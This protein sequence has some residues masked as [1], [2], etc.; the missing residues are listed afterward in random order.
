MYIP[1]AIRQDI[2]IPSLQPVRAANL[3]QHLLSRLQTEVIRIIQ[4]QLA[5]ALGEL[6]IRETFQRR[7]GRNGHEDGK[8]NGAMGKMEGAGAGFRCLLEAIIRYIDTKPTQGPD[9]DQIRYL[10]F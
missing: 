10:G 7:L 3:V 6:V 1:T 9:V 8:R 5:A 2:P 4:A